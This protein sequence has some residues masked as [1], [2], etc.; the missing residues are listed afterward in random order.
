M[1]VSIALLMKE[2]TYD[3][4]IFNSDQE[5]ENSS[6]DVNSNTSNEWS[7]FQNRQP[8]FQC[9]AKNTSKFHLIQNAEYRLYVIELNEVVKSKD[10][11]ITNDRKMKM[12]F[13]TIM[14]ETC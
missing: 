14:Y 8:T 5:S 7:E 4:Q 10:G 13:H 2:E 3:S 6:K 1:A 12:F 11:Q 9:T